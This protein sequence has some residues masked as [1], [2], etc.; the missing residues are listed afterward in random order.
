MNIRPLLRSLPVSLFILWC[1]AWL[2]P[3]RERAEWLAEWQ[4]ELWHVWHSYSRKSRGCFRGGQEVTDFC[5]GAFHDAFW[6]RWSNPRSIPR[7]VFRVGSAS[8]CSLSLAA[9]V[10]IS[11]LIC[12]SLPNANEMIRPSP[13]R[14]SDGLVMISSGGYSGA[15]LPSIRFR[16]YQSWKTSTRRLF[17]GV[18]FY[19]PILKRV[20]IARHRA[21]ELAIGR[22]SDNLF[23]LLNLPVS[24]DAGDPSGGY[25]ARLFLSQAAWRGLFGGDPRTI[26]SVTEIAGQ[27]VLIAGVISQDS[28]QLP[29]RVDA[30]LLEDERHLAKLPLSSRGFVLAH[31]RTAGSLPQLDGWRYM[32]V[33]GDDGSTDRFDCI[34]LAQRTRLPFSIFLFSLIVAFMALP[35]TTALPLGE[36][37]RHSGRLT[38]AV[39]MRRWI[40]LWSKFVL[41]VTLVYFTSVDIA[42]GGHPLG[43]TRAQYIQLAISFFGFL[44]AFRWILQDQRKRCPVC[45][46]VLSNPARV[47]QASRN[48]LAWNGTELICA[49][50]HGLLHIPELP[51]SWFSTQRWLYLDASWGSLFPDGRMP[52]AGFV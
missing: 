40:F 41:I 21:Q 45:L 12:L 18:A 10:A 3:G 49:G 33:H 4:A 44:F 9:W 22:A 2:V 14:D 42:Y 52:Y 13:Y 37:P 27:R 1:A 26:G 11:F 31:M 17:T 8:R 7:R 36:Y 35:A 39:R 25:A 48:F 15:Q 20:H 16:D 24:A 28:W 46:R 47:G 19:Q 38:W 50:G 51:T 34:S 29:G 5:L 30:W 43:S 23:K 32:A 6:F